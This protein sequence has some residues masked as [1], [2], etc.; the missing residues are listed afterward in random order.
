[1]DSLIGAHGARALPRL[2]RAATWFSAALLSLVLAGSCSSGAGAS[3]DQCNP[4]TGA[5]CPAGGYACD[6]EASSG[7][8]LCYPPPNPVAV[9]GSCSDISS[10]CGTGLSCVLQ[11]S[12]TISSCY[13]YC[14]TDAD[15]GSGGTCDTAFM[16]SLRQPTNA[17]DV[18]G[19][20]VTSTTVEAPACAPPATAPSGG[21]CVR[22][23]STGADGGTPDAGGPDGGEPND[24]GA[25]PPDGGPPDGG[26][27]DAG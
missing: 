26:S 18:I 21:T 14:C 2:V 3:A 10:A 4:V 6:F 17:G 25:S 27:L 15:C 24:G 9:C 23:F 16:E 12:T 20:C 13:R 7:Y 5:G 1:M 8:F 19:L 22:G 11:P